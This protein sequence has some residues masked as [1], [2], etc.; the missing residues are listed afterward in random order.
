[1]NIE[2]LKKRPTR[3]S[4]NNFILS[5]WLQSYQ[6]QFRN[7]HI[8][9]YFKHYRP[10]VEKILSVS[11]GVVMHP[12]DDDDHILG[13]C[14]YRFLSDTPVVSFIYVKHT[15]RNMGIGREMWKIFSS[16]DA[17]LITHT[18]KGLNLGKNVIYDP[19]EDLKYL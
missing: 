16:H 10:M 9:V 8:D 5:S 19:F 13:F 12:G 3:Q 15:Y 4:D 7:V 6:R 14:I 11:R 2:N 1:M 17:V 18:V